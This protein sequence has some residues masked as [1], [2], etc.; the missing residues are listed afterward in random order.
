[1]NVLTP[2]LALIIKQ[3]GEEI[4]DEMAMEACDVLDVIE[5]L[6]DDGQ[7]R[8]HM[9][10]WDESGFTVGTEAFDL[11]SEIA[12]SI[13]DKFM[14]ND[15][16]PAIEHRLRK[17]GL[18]KGDDSRREQAQELRIEVWGFNR[19]PQRIHVLRQSGGDLVL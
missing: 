19:K 16:T 6:D 4:L 12:P 11:A 5:A 8:E 7:T 17:Q 2:E 15:G 10:K 13:W 18:R 3:C 14:P 9:C 1:M